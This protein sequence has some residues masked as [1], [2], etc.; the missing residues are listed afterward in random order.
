MIGAS[1]AADVMRQNKQFVLVL[2]ETMSS[3]T[4][5]MFINSEHDV[6]QNALLILI[7]DFKSPGYSGICIH[8]LQSA[9]QSDCE[10]ENLSYA[11][12]CSSNEEN[13]P[14]PARTVPIDPEPPDHSVPNDTMPAT[15]EAC[16]PIFP[17]EIVEPPPAY[18]REIND[19][20]CQSNT[21]SSLRK[22]NRK[23]GPP[24]WMESGEWD[25]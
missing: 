2:H 4:R 19:I 14:M 24:S 9:P 25:L 22:S 10:S 18:H 7:A 13:V 1:F 20:E 8:G 5:G 12:Q 23:P 3:F 17:S 15:I 16:Q 11:E 6:L 21:G